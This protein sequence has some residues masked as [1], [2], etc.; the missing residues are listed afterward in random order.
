MGADSA[1][2]YQWYPFMNGH[3]QLA[4][5]GNAAV[6]KEFIRNLR[7]DSK[8]VRERAAGDPFY[9]GVP[10]IWCSNN[11]TVALLTQWVL[12]RELSYIIRTNE[13][14]FVVELA[15]MM[16]IRGAA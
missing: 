11:L 8:R 12:Y 14:A 3:Y 1:R 10:A 5:N 4:Y 16:Q 6:R 9:Y 15:L 7:T 13:M 2:H